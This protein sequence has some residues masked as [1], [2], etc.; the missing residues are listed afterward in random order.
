MDELG[1]A[2]FDKWITNVSDLTWKEDI[3]DVI[4]LI[5]IFVED[6]VTS[7]VNVWNLTDLNPKTLLNS[8][9]V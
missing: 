9:V 6:R 4:T 2:D 3:L 7:W 8:K 1:F 5:T